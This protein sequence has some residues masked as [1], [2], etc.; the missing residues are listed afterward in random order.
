MHTKH[1]PRLQDQPRASSVLSFRAARSFKPR[2]KFAWSGGGHRGSTGS[3]EGKRFPRIEFSS[4]D[5]RRLLGPAKWLSAAVA[6]AACI[7]YEMHTS[8]LESR[9]LSYYA[10]KLTYSVEAG[11]SDQIIFPKSG[12]L[13]EARGYTR[14]PAIAKRLGAQGF[15][16]KAQARFSSELA[17]IARWG[18][19]PPYRDRPGAGLTLRSRE[20]EVL[21]DSS[22]SRELFKSYEDIPQLVSDSLLFIE[23]RNLS[24]ESTDPWANPVL[25]WDRLA[26]ASLLYVGIKLGLPLHLEG[27]STLATQLEKYLHSPNG[28]TSSVSDK[29]R[30][31]TG[32]TLRAYREGPDT[33]AVRRQLIVD[34][35]NSVPLAAAPGYG[36][37]HGLGDGLR[38]WFG[39]DLG[40]VSSELDEDGP[41]AARARAFKHVLALLTAARAPNLYL[42]ENRS[43]L[44]EKANYYARLLARAGEID[45]GFAEETERAA[46][47]FVPS[48]PVPSREYT[49]D[50][51]T[52]TALRSQLMRL[53][54]T[55][56]LYALDQVNLQADTTIDA[57]LEDQV[58]KTF[59]DLRENK[60]LD[61]HGLRERHL[62]PQGDPQKVNYSFL[63]YERTP[64][65]NLLRASMDTLPQPFDLNSGMK[66]ELGS[67]AKLRTLANYLQVVTAL[68]GELSNLDIP[69]R[70]ERARTAR[71]P[72][73]RWAA[74][75]LVLEHSLD[76]NSF[77]EKSL[78]RTYSA[79]P[80]EVFFTGGGSHTF[81][82]FE[83]EDNGRILTVREAITRS[84][85][86]VFIRLMGDMVRFYEVRL[87]F[88]PDE[89]LGQ[90]DN[91]VRIQLLKQVAE[92]ESRQ[93]LGRAFE[94][95]RGLSQDGRISKLMGSGRLTARSLAILYLAWHSDAKE[96]REKGLAQWLAAHGQDSSPDA[97]RRLVK[98]YG[99]PRLNLAD[100]AYL[101]HKNPIDLW[102]AGELDRHRDISW[103]QLWESSGSACA[104]GSAWLF[105]SRNRRAQDLRLRIRIEEEAFE[106][107]TPY[108]RKLGFP[109]EHLVPSY[110]TAIGS[111]SDRPAALAELMGIIL[112]DGVRLP[113]ISLKEL[114]FARGT[115]YETV[116]EHVPGSGKKVMNPAVARVLR[117]ALAG[118]VQ[119]GTARRVA[120]AFGM[121]DGTPVTAGGKTGSGDNRFE[122][123]GPR[124]VKISSRPVSRTATFVFY[125][126]DR[127][128]G[129]ITAYVGGDNA[130]QYSFTSALPVSILRLLAPAI[131]DLLA[132]RD[133]PAAHRAPVETLAFS[134]GSLNRNAGATV[135]PPADS[136]RSEMPQPKRNKPDADLRRFMQTRTCNNPRE[137]ASS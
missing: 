81:Q 87:P 88:D 34:Y 3:L 13:D 5:W 80:H 104:Q 43:A 100:Y 47:N 36:E 64:E 101:L 49:A 60:F 95:Y 40:Q 133:Y 26:K 53:L 111:S 108:W 117:G 75:T 59:A 131:N 114:D 110:A 109:F 61:S 115:P 30:Q 136:T 12:P 70:E 106:R 66:L 116:F 42:V 89:V 41:S 78:D 52:A 122:V 97:V 46:L 29:F 128:F 55:R 124:G 22:D 85:N 129:V 123:F 37:V 48:S 94:S 10:E 93:A 103:S 57:G 86:L 6:I 127:Y 137:S 32:A 63:L 14:I 120:G 73:T 2:L 113:A 68:Y 38:A 98:A 102:C 11:S 18:I 96:N 39:M 134:L 58:A 15:K 1:S 84:V 90:Q 118:V 62:L 24:F 44:N 99:N 79:N 25:D 74:Q 20:S 23:N 8:A 56:D 50:N 67:T 9:I 76:L 82:N 130:A 77:L 135:W 132:G 71:D 35:L 54:G 51:K 125:V 27:G 65:G 92:E 69:A 28:R 83:P 17:R 16:V 21:Y 112:N 126:G 31:M 19:A 119:I 45:R 121:P 105:E 4:A 7:A 33:R 107:M 72:I 91:P